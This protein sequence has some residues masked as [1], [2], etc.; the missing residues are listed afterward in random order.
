MS[1]AKWS[2]EA[3]YANA[4]LK[5]VKL[6]FSRSGLYVTALLLGEVIRVA[7]YETSTELARCKV[8]RRKKIK[9]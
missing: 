1:K 9:K 6:A 7:E 3:D 4:V 8:Q 5:D 2:V